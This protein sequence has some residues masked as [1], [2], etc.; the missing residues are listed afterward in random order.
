MRKKM[1]IGRIL[2][3]TGLVLSLSMALVIGGG[4]YWWSENKDRVLGQFV[5]ER[6][7]GVAFGKSTDNEGCFAESL[8]R[9]DTCGTFPCHLK[10]NL[11]L[12]GC[13]KESNPTPGFCDDVP[14]KKEFMKTVTWRVSQ[15]SETDR[16]GSYCHELFGTVQ[17]FCSRAPDLLSRPNQHPIALAK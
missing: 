16:E 7:E 4:V 14:A 9:H 12:F 17:K 11:F 5:E 10:N 6:D 15:C 13:L 3:I 2:L 1:P 8:H